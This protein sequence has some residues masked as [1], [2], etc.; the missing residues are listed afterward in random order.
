MKTLTMEL[1]DNVFAATRNDP[2]HF[3][4]EMRL[5]AA[6]TWYEQGRIS[7]EIAA[8]VAGLDRTDFL[9]ALS[10]MRKNSF[11]VDFDDLDRELADD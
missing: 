4:K 6:V 7:Q 5:A 1:P 8:E 2:A 10:S 11:T 3:S 9:M